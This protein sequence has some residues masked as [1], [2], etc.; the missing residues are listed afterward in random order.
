MPAGYESKMHSNV[1]LVYI[2]VLTYNGR[3]WLGDCITSILGL[4]YPNFKV[5]VID[6]GS[7]DGSS[8]FV[9]TQFPQAYIIENGRNL[10]YARGF[11]TGLVYAYDQ[12]ADFFLVMNDDTIIDPHALS[13]LVETA[14][15]QDRAGF[16]SGKVYYY[17]RPNV[18]QT[19]GKHLDPIRWS[20]GSIGWQET[21]TGQYDEVAERAFMDDVYMLVR[22]EMYEGVGGYDPQF[23]LMAPQFDWQVRAKKKGWRLYYTPHAKIWHRVSMSTGGAGSPTNE[24]FYSRSTLIVMARHAGFKRY[25][26]YWVWLGYHRSRSLAF[27][28]R[29]V[30]NFNSRLAGWLGWIDGTLWLLHRRPTT[31]VPWMIQWL[32]KTSGVSG[33]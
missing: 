28:L 19:V 23:F 3:R 16:V 27:G 6:N 14:I 25:I 7:T 13:A 20:G 2:L 33:K 10:G 12:G 9:R 11:N 1:P 15:S 24:Y 29:G 31:G 22:R 4:D 5:A 30:P 26:R 17:D 18:L 21:D 8:T 32:Q